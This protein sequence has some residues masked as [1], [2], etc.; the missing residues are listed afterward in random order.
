LPCSLSPESAPA[1]IAGLLTIIR[2]NK[3]KSKEM[4]V[5]FLYATASSPH[6]TSIFMIDQSQ[7]ADP[8]R[9]WPR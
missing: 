9:Q 1:E 8:L 7:L 6:L 4:R 5:L 2:K 3:A